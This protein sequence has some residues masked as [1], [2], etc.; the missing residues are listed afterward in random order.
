MIISHLLLMILIII[1]FMILKLKPR[2]SSQLMKVSWRLFNSLLQVKPIKY[3][4]DEVEKYD[5]YNVII[6]PL[7]LIII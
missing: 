1:I 7:H 5:Q 4:E 3:F 2:L 6:F